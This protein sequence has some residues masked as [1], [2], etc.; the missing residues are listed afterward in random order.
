MAE[1]LKQHGG[2]TEA[3]LAAVSSLGSV[4]EDLV[5]L[6]DI[7]LQASL[8]AAASRRADDAEATATY[9]SSSRR[10][11]VRFRI[12]RFHREGGLGR[13]YVARQEELT[14]RSRSRGSGPTGYMRRSR[15]GSPRGRHHR[16]LAAPRHRA[17]LRPEP[18]CGRPVLHHAAHPRPD[19]ER[20]DCQLP[21]EARKVEEARAA[22]P[23]ACYRRSSASA[24]QSATPIRV[25]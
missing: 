23:T 21:S 24:G 15:G 14:G 16:P 1:H 17:D 20:G 13:V 25:A 9:T 3:S 22:N 6:D 11:G 4:R 18:G 5:R 12:L 19:L 8:A 7:G 2:D 10:A